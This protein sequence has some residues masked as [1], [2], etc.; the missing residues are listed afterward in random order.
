MRPSTTYAALVL[1]AAALAAAGVMPG[2]SFSDSRRQNLKRAN[3]VTTATS[4]SGKSFDY[5]IIGVSL[6][7]DGSLVPLL[8]AG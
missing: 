4:L 6:P 8:F 1:S 2:S 3:T 5:V 7:L